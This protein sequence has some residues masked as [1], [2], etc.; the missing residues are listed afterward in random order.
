VVINMHETHDT[1]D[2]IPDDL[3]GIRP[4]P[5]FA[6]LGADKQERIVAEALDE[7]AEHGFEGA[8]VN[9]LVARLSIAKGS[10][11][12]Y[13]GT[14]ERLF[15]YVFERVA[16]RFAAA[17]RAVRDETKD[18]HV[19]ARIRASL[20]AGVVFIDAHPRIYRLYVRVSL[21]ENVP[22]RGRLLDEAR[23]QSARYLRRL[24]TDGLARGELKPGLDVDAAVFFLDALMDRF[25]LAYAVDF[26]DAG[27]GLYRAAP[28]VLSAKLEALMDL[29]AGALAARPAKDEKR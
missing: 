23:R 10:I 12:Q 5:T 21:Q 7:F 25:L 3:A 14:K 2:D 15:A 1:L 11:F 19:L 18:A 4:S 13:F 24:V 29:I 20:M 28:E 26:L 8:S 16:G 22:L 27:T 9:R 17:L 6:A